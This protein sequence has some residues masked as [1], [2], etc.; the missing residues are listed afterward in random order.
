MESISASHTL[1]VVAA[2]AWWPDGK[3]LQELQHQ[4]DHLLGLL[5]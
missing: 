2:M 3:H 5:N 4:N 1:V